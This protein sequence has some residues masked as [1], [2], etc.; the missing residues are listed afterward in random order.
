ME[1]QSQILFRFNVL[2]GNGEKLIMPNTPTL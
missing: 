1:I 2:R